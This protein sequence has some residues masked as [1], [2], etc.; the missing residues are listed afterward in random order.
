MSFAVCLFV[1]F[2]DS[3]IQRRGQGIVDCENGMAQ[4]LKC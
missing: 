3:D 2:R 1:C 4:R